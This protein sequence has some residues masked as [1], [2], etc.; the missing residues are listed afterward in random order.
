MDN[1]TVL[2]S[3]IF[4]TRLGEGGNISRR[5]YNLVLGLCLLWGFVFNFF[6]VV[7]FGDAICKFAT[8]GVGNYIIFIVAYF[9]LAITGIIINVKSDKPATS[10]LGYNLVVLP[11]GATLAIIL[12][13]YPVMTISYA[14]GATALLTLLMI[15]LSV[16]FPKFFLSI[17]RGLFIS[18]LCIILIEFVCVFL[19]RLDFTIIDIAVAVIFCGYIGFDWARAQL[20]PSSVDNAIDSACALYLDI[21]NLFIRLLRIFGRSR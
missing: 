3:S 5:V 18:L 8:S 2:G 10:F 4:K 21:V 13:A 6:V 15:V 11:L 9:A 14:F 19:F 16:S 12:Q 7:F 20:I 1:S 17:G